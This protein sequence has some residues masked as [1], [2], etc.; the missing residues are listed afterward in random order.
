[1]KGCA[2][3]GFLPE[4]GVRNQRVNRLRVLRQQ[5]GWVQVQL[6][7]KAHVSPQLISAIELYSYPPGLHIRQRIADALEVS[8]DD[9]WPPESQES[10]A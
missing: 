4:S 5:R 2:V 1:L 7:A 10:V 3:P 8:V 9:V 6:A